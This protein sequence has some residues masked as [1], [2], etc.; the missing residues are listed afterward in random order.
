MR[1][2]YSS[3]SKRDEVVTHYLKKKEG[4]QLGFRCDSDRKITIEDED[5]CFRL[6]RQQIRPESAPKVARKNK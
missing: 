1:G 4:N 6:P 2:F 3:R 5:F